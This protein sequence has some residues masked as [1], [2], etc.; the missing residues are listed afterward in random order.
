MLEDLMNAE[1]VI[2]TRCGSFCQ[3][4][5]EVDGKPVGG[6]AP[7]LLRAL[8]HELLEEYLEYTHQK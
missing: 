4:V 5:C 7:E 6:K 2:V 3:P 8:Q 1:E